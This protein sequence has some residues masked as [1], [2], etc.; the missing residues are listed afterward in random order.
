MKW[1]KKIMRGTISKTID[2]FYAGNPKAHSTSNRSVYYEA[3]DLDCLYSYGPHYLLAKKYR[4]KKAATESQNRFTDWLVTLVNKTGDSATTN[5]MSSACL[6]REGSIEV[7]DP[8]DPAFSHAMMCV[9]VGVLF[10]KLSRRRTNQRWAIAGISHVVSDI[11]RLEDFFG[12]EP[13]NI[14][15][16]KKLSLKLVQWRLEG[17]LSINNWPQLLE[18]INERKEKIKSSRVQAA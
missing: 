13:D 8:N 18:K 5:K 7:L 11:A 16:P 15:I 1:H 17:S 12:L 9:E 10:D 4:I 6:K 14:E 3:D 2:A